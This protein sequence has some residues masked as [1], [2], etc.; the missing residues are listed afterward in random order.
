MGVPDVLAVT[1]ADVDGHMNWD[2]SGGWWI[3]MAL[4]MALFWG[5]VILGIVWVVREGT[6]SHHRG[7]GPPDRSDP[8]SVLDHRLAEGA[9]TPDE[10]RERRAML[11]GDGDKQGREG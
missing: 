10:Y 7:G 2:V 4:G 5:L 3:V 6:G 9:I 11:T 1:V 8:L